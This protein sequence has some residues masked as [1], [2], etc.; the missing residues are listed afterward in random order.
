MVLF[1]RMINTPTKQLR[2]DIIQRLDNSI[3]ENIDESQHEHF[4]TI[5]RSYVSISESLIESSLI[6]DTVIVTFLIFIFF[7]M[8]IF[9]L[10]FCFVLEIAYIV[11]ICICFDAELF[12]IDIMIRVWIAKYYN[13]NDDVIDSMINEKILNDYSNCNIIKGSQYQNIFTLERIKR[14]IGYTY[15]YEELFGENKYKVTKLFD[16]N[17]FDMIA[18]NVL[19]DIIIL[20]IYDTTTYLKFTSEYQNKYQ[21]VVPGKK[22]YKKTKTISGCLISIMR[23]RKMLK[24]LKFQ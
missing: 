20:D 3:L 2:K 24:M 14:N 12:M 16:Y 17:L 18:S 1:L 21:Y 7:L 19:N 5:L 15:C 6:I 9:S 10:F 11:I 22:I 13:I 4:N 23:H 8:S